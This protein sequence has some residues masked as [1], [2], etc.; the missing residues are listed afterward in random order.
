MP[1]PRSPPSNDEP[2]DDGGAARPSGESGRRSTEQLRRRVEEQYDFDDFGPSDMA[3]MSSEEWAA[4]FDPDTWI[5][6]TE[7]LDRVMAD[8]ERRVADREVFARLERMEDPD[9][10]VTYSDEG[11]AVVYADGS[12]T[13]RGTVLRDVKPSVALCSM[14]DYEVP[15]PPADAALPDPMEVPE[16]TGGL[17]HL[18]LLFVGGVQLLA[19]LLLAVLWVLSELGLIPLVVG[20]GF[21]FIGIVMLVLVANARLS[22]R[23]RAEEYRNRLRAVGID[24]DGPQ[25]ALA[26]R[27]PEDVPAEL[28]DLVA[29]P[30]RAPSTDTPA[31]TGEDP[32]ST[33]DRNR[34]D[35]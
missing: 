13:G 2:E 18:M 9:R 16:G 35:T 1:D 31:P 27:S 23:F 12:V 3:E 29:G 8:L 7:L 25:V 28:R 34:P 19:G 24:D 5:T 15:D 17:G 22:D 26:D 33:E 10:L 6:G 30:E 21:L 32:T 4:A 11:Y 20:L 14:D